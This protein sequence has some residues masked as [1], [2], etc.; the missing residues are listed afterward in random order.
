MGPA[1]ILAVLAAATL[2]VSILTWGSLGSGVL[3][4]CLITMAAGIL[5]QKF[6]TNRD[7]DYFQDEG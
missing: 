5:Y 6:L 4:F 7:E 1:V 2:A 3:L